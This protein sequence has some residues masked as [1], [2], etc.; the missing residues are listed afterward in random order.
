MRELATR[1]RVE[2]LMEAFGRAAD[3][4]VRVYLV[5]GATAVLM[6]WR[7]TTVDVDLVM[8]PE[9]DQLF[10]AIPELKE[11]LRVNIETASPVDFIPIPAGWEDRGT[12]IAQKGSVTFYHFDLYGQA[13]AK[14]ERGHRQDLDDVRA[15]VTRGLVD[16][17]RAREYFARIEPE[18]HRFPAIHAPAFARAVDEA[19]PA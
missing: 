5:G 2:A 6:G 18:L 1:A 12:F 3:R 16:P 10:R 13:L 14:V 17:R 8:R 4:P 15:M 19:F 11:A 7:N 9:S